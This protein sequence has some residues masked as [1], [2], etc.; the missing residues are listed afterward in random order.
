MA[1]QARGESEKLVVYLLDDFYR[2]LEPVGRLNIVGEL[3]K[4]AID[5]YQ[6]LP[7]ELRTPDTERNQALAQVRYGAVLRIQS[8]HDEARKVLARGDSGPRCAAREGRYQRSRRD[9]T[10]A[11]AGGAI[12]RGGLDWPGPRLLCRRHSEQWLSWRRWPRRV[13][14]VS[15]CGARMGLR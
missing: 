1:E 9:R 8:K 14:R 4:R 7:A 10:R 6:A 5:Y 3:A 13:A 2:E 11:R 12:A 15:P